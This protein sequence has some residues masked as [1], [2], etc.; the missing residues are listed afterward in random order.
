MRKLILLSWALSAAVTITHAQTSQGRAPIALPK[1]PPTVDQILSLA[2]AGAP[3]ISP[4]GRF[5]AY[6]VRTANW[7]D[8]SYDTQIWLAETRGAG[9]PRQLTTGKKS[10]TSP[11]WSPDGSRLAFASDRTDKRQIYLINPLG[12]EAEAITTLEDG[13]GSFAWSPDGRSIAFTSTEPK[14]A[15]LKDRD[16]KYGEFQV[17]E[18]D[19][20]MS[21]LSILDVEKKTT[22]A[23]TTGAFT[24]GRFAWS[25]DGT[26]IAFD[27]TINTSPASSGSADISI[28]T[29]ATGSIR[30]LV[31]Q[32]GPDSHPV[33][34]PDGATIAFET[35]MANPAYFYANRVVAT[36]PASGGTPSVLT[37]T[38][39][40]DPSIAGWNRAGLFFSASQKTYAGLFRL[41]P[42]TKTSTRTGP[43][44]NTVLSGVSFTHDGSRIAF[45]SSDATSMSE[46]FVA[47]VASGPG[48]TPP[49]TKLTDFNAQTRGW[50]TS[51][52]DVVSW[53][54]QDGATIEGVLHK[55]TDFDA[56]KKYPLLVVIHGGPTGISRAI[57]FTS[58]IYPIDVWVPRGV[59][60]LEPNYRGSAG[61]G[62][63]FRA[64]NV[65]N[66]GV[67]DAWDVLSGVDSL[68]AKGIVDKDNVG[69]M[70]W[71]QGGY[72]SAFLA[73][74]D[75]AR[76]KA[77]SVGAGISDWMTYYV[78]TDIHP[79]TRQYLQA[80]PWDDPAIYSK[81][82]PIT[83]IKQ[84]KTPTLI[85]HGATDQRVPLPNAFELYQGLKDNN[86]PTKL[87]VYQG[88]GG[89][90]H[91]PSKPKS[92]RATM[93]HNL[94]WFD[95]WM[96]K[97]DSKATTAGAK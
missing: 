86:V 38:F 31:T 71:S 41:D 34:S 64:L 66:L 8:N 62:E 26:M 30:K 53:K 18:Q 82:S 2:R 63:K 67:G 68:I 80:T 74:H 57:P 65:K 95:Q 54:S 46:V 33:W 73:T 60:V 77:I 22:K 79:F 88:F 75:A 48:R 27:H 17:V 40:E 5:V 24:V 3:E 35:A 55:P 85:Q 19:Y 45:L 6:V 83:Y 10:S 58:T 20:R 97:T 23:V 25:P 51:T 50:A 69:V 42:A 49:A 29:V 12:G 16:K 1:Q 52:L 39:D 70:G 15:A 32:D 90:G 4:D 72:I 92:F 76:F 93:E 43:A 84:A 9:T 37:A 78:N 81:T 89:I 61:Y 87:Y 21:H 44:G 13:V 94:E 36:I 28:V 56:A 7:D 47:D 91:G 11:A 59:L 96:F 14:S